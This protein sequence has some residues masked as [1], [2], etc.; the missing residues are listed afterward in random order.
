MDAADGV[1]W[2]EG[3]LEGGLEAPAWGDV[4]VRGTGGD[5]C[6]FGG[7][8]GSSVACVDYGASAEES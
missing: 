8:T 1:A 3:G 4:A 7:G 5:G 2:V 6:G